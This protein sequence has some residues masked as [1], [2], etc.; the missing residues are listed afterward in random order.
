MPT[1]ERARWRSIVVDSPRRIRSKRRL[2]DGPEWCFSCLA[3]RVLCIRTVVLVE[4]S[5]GRQK[6]CNVL[7][8]LNILQRF[9]RGTHTKTVIREETSQPKRKA[10]A[11][12]RRRK[13]HSRP[14]GRGKTSTLRCRRE[15]T[16]CQRECH[17]KRMPCR[18]RVHSTTEI[19]YIP[20]SPTR[21]FL[22]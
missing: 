6:R 11:V 18:S 7:V 22:I 2:A 14:S 10:V 12:V 16:A 20:H 13:H 21:F 8:C 5:P 15:P 1:H 9:D 3:L 19:Y 4:S 17:G